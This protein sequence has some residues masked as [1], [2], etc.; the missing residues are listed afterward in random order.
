M[1]THWAIFVDNDSQKAAFTNAVLHN[2]HPYFK[3][4]DQQKGA[5]FSSLAITQF[6]NEEERH[7]SSKLNDAVQ[8]LK[9]MSSGEQKKALLNHILANNPDY[10]ILD[11]PFDNLDT[12]FQQELK[13]LLQTKAGQI[14][15]LQLV[16]RKTD[17]LPFVTHFGALVENDFTKLT[18][19][20]VESVLQNKFHFAGNLPQPIHAVPYSDTS[21]IEIKN[22]SISYE[23]KSVLKDISWTIKP[24][25]FWQLIG[26]NGS[27]KSTLLSMIIGDNPKAYRKDIY[28]FGK[29]K[30]SGESVWDIKEKIGYFSPA[31]TDKFAGRHS[32][33]HML[34]SGFNDSIGLYTK[35]TD[36]QQ[37]CIGEW[38]RLLNLKK[39]KNTLFKDLSLGEQ[40]L[41]MT[42]RAMV[43]HPPVLLLDEP[44]AGMDDASAELLVALVNKIANHSYT[45]IIFVSHRM[46]KGLLPKATYSL[47]MTPDGSMGT[48]KTHS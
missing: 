1:T 9:T 24:G 16:S 47:T 27:G 2:K 36:A 43:K 30:G 20:A 42:A 31:M 3:Y 45:A 23:G 4:F 11:N 8:P 6:I 29:K 12:D 18:K 35:P 34:I 7:G 48:S 39:K 38:L 25:D 10:I 28:L 19:T 46:E 40:R 26:K 33:A 5:L 37:Q 32:V 41:V 44:T 15:F 22:V 13:Q 14:G 17:L 21:L